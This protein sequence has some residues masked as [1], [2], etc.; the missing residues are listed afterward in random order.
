MRLFDVFDAWM[1][2][3]LVVL[4]FLAAFLLLRFVLNRRF[5]ASFGFQFRNQLILLLMTLAGVLTFILAL[6]TGESTKSQLISLIG[7]LLSATIALSATTFLGNIMAGLMLRVVRN[8]GPGDFIRVGD[9]L[10]RVSEQGLFH[11]E[12]QTEDRD[13]HTLPNLQ[14]VTQ[15]VKV[16]RSSGTLVSAEVSLG[17]DVSRLR[18]KQLLLRAGE[19]AGLEG[20][21]VHVVDLGDFSVNYRLSGLLRDVKN[22]FSTRSILMEMML[23]HLHAGGVEI[24]SPSFMNQRS[25]REDQIMIPHVSRRSTLEDSGQAFERVA[26]DKAEDAE[27]V[28]RLQERYQIVMKQVDEMKKE[29]K[30]IEEES[31]KARLESQIEHRKKMLERFER[32][33]SESEDHNQESKD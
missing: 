21:F 27:S 22:L 30:S 8:F 16:I 33:I 9:T 7:I 31:E 28:A 10:G 20:S 1:P 3:T 5:S 17:Y 12:I 19:E 26:F 15:P 11:V 13:L 23:D 4:F 32:L 24:V 18:V 25:L 14:L 29:L 6:P 2:A